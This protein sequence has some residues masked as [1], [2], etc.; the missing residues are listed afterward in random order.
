MYGDGDDVDLGDGVAVGL[1]CLFDG[2]GGWD[3][4]VLGVFFGPLD[5]GDHGECAGEAEELLWGESFAVEESPEDA[6]EGND[7]GDEAGEEWSFGLDEFEEDPGGDAGAD[8]AHPCHTCDTEPDV[9]VHFE[10]LGFDDD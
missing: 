4:E 9:F 10:V 5:D 3:V 1:S 6:D 8:D 2:F 7:V